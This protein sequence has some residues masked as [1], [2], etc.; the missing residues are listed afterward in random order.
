M[1]KLKFPFFMLAIAIALTASF[2]FKPASKYSGKSTTYYYQSDSPDLN[3][4]KNFSLWNSIDVP[5]SCGAIGSIPCA[6]NYDDDFEAHLA[7]YSDADVLKAD[8]ASRR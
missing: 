1:K 5:A 2:A 4:M 6:F 3:D 7:T 8:A